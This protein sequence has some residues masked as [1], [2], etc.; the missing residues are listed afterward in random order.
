[1]TASFLKT[2]LS[3]LADLN[4]AVV[5]MVSTRPF[6]SK[7][8]SQSFGDCTERNDYNSCSIVFF[9]FSSK[10]EVLTLLFAFFRVYPVVNRNGQVHYL[11]DLL[12]LLLL[13]ITR[14]GCLAEIS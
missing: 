7:S 3:I 13:T 5:W 14:S 11:A 2:L 10:V 12:L 1:M 4:K 9:Q 6:I 8:S